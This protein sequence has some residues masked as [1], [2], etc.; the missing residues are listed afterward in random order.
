MSREGKVKFFNSEKGFGFITPNDGSEDLFVHFSSIMSEGFKSL[1]DGENVTFD[2]E[3]DAQKGKTKAINVTGDGTGQVR[4]R[5]G[6]GR[7]GGGRGGGRGF[8]G[9]GR[10]GDRFDGGQGNY[11]RGDGGY[12]GGGGNYAP[13][14]GGG[15]Y[16]P[17][18]G[19]GG[20]GGGGGY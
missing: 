2:D 10:G 15:N 7:G 3:F 5:G 14:G 18:G 1:N 12:S 6:G 20:Y 8:G 4:Q 11:G 19:D 13:S 16:A 17:S 9:E